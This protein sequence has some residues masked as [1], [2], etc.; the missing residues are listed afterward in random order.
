MPTIVNPKFQSLYAD[1]IQLPVTFN[2]GQGEIVYEARN[3]LRKET[4]RNM[5]V[6]VKSFHKP[7]FLNRIVYTFFRKSKALRSYTFSEQLTRLGIHTPTP[8]ACI[9]EQSGHLI[10]R[11]YYINLFEESD[12]VRDLMDGRVKGNEKILD[13]FSRF[14][15]DVHQKGVLHLDLSPG[16][17]LFRLTEK[18]DYEFSLIDVN[19]MRF[20]C[21][22]DQKKASYNVRR[23]CTSREVSGY[24]ARRYAQLRG[25]DADDMEEL[26]QHDSDR[27]FRKFF[28]HRTATRS[29]QK[30][31]RFIILCFRIL[32]YFRTHWL[33]ENSKTATYIH[34]KEKSLYR[35][36]FSEYDFRRLFLEELGKKEYL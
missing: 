10:S 3:M 14:M 19:R 6:V 23:L 15:V 28:F 21:T 22:I 5:T 27:F 12:T 4:L 35:S 2:M 32:R 29:K 30:G 9:I 36:Y 26:V 17:I 20:G 16:N 25:W 34:N 7:A 8:I 31:I 11:S 13:D 24:I 1:I 18:G 33:K